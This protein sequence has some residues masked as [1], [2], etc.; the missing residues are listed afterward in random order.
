M[1]DFNGTHINVP[2]DSVVDGDTIKVEL[3][4]P[5]GIQSIRILCLDTEE[6]PGSGGSKPKTPWGQK[7]TERAE[8]FFQGAQQVTL[9]FPGTESAEVCLQ[10]YRGNF[11][12]VLAYVYVG[13]QDFQEVMVREGFSPYFTKY[14]NANF[15][16]NHHRYRCA[17]REAQMANI[18]VWN[19]ILVNG[20]ER[21]NYASLSTWWNLRAMLIDQYRAHLAAGKTI[22]N[23]RLDYQLI[24]QK[25]QE[26]KT[27]T[28][29]TEV[30]R[31]ATI[32]NDSIGFVDIGSEAQ[33][34]TLFLP[35]LNMPEGQKIAN[36]LRLR[37]ISDGTDD[38]HPRRSYL[39]VTGALSIFN[40]N[41]QMVISSIDQMT[42]IFKED[43][44]DQNPNPTPVADIAIVG[45]L[46]NPAGPDAGRE[47]VTLKNNVNVAQSLEG[48]VLKDAADNHMVL[49]P[50]T[51]G[52]GATDEFTVQGQLSLNNSGDEITLLDKDGNQKSQ[53]AYTASQVVSGQP[54][55]F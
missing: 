32:N 18:G 35:N 19:Q 6:K 55:F 53:V 41:P 15:D 54:I 27:V 51:L 38:D 7:A 42:D 39:Y 34:F 4:N 2:L 47:T 12:R 11:N 26:S 24:K 21:R 49:G 33:P 30:R 8:R 40:D 10:K 22:Y 1:S 29:F 5:H 13:E 17:E 46:P 45:L 28:L 48:W 44:D 20:E 50:T 43:G 16:D 31:L 36:L 52:P 9:E 37:Y 14:G 23:T 3:P 25:A